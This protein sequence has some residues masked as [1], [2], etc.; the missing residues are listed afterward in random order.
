MLTLLPRLD[1][2]AAYLLLAQ[3]VNARPAYLCR[4][5]GPWNIAKFLEEFDE[6]VDECLA[7]IAEL[8]NPLPEWSKQIRGLPAKQ[9]GACVRRLRDTAFS[10]YSASFLKASGVIRAVFSR[11]WDAA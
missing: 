9:S 10:A 6:K 2:H 4:I 5:V 8:Q 1:N 7:K 11:I 3:C